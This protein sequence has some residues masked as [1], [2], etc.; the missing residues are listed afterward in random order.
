LYKSKTVMVITKQVPVQISA[1]IRSYSSRAR[2]AL[3]ALRMRLRSARAT[4]ALLVLLTLGL[5]EPLLCIVHCQIWLPIAYHSYFAAQ[6][7]HMHHGSQ[8]VM[9]DTAGIANGALLA[10]PLPGNDASCF[11]LRADGNHDGA[12]FHVVP[13]PVHDILPTLMALLMLIWLT[14]ARPA[15]PPDDPP[16]IAYPPRLRPPIPFAA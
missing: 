1:T 8:H 13:S 12:P 2:R 9:S 10:S 6:H 16:R 5:G 3:R 14:S 11:M 4:V 15:A 7:A